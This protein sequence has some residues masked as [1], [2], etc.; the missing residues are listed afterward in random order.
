MHAIRLHESQVGLR[1]ALDA[2]EKAWL[3]EPNEETLARITEIKRLLL[4]PVDAGDGSEV[5]PSS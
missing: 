2:A 1:R 5:T 4:R 3:A